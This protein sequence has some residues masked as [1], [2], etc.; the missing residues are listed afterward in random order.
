MIEPPRA[1]IAACD[2]DAE[3]LRLM[4]EDNP[5]L[6]ARAARCAQLDTLIEALAAEAQNTG[7]RRRLAYLKA[8]REALLAEMVAMVLDGEAT[9]APKSAAPPPRLRHNPWS[10]PA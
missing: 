2:A 9:P 10:W 7:M 4:Q 8:E 5:F 6:M 3:A 1:L